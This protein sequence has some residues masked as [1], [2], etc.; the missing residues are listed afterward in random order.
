MSASPE[1]LSSAVLKTKVGLLTNLAPRSS[2]TNEA[3]YADLTAAAQA[4]LRQGDVQLVVDLGAVQVI[5]SA[6]LLTLADIQD[7]AVRL[8]GWL[9]LAHANAIV[10]D[11][12]RLTGFN[13]YVTLMD[14]PA[15]SRHPPGTSP[16]LGD[17][18]VSRG[19]VSEA[20]VEEAIAL[21]KTTSMRMGQIIIDKGW[22]SE[23]DVLSALGEQLDV[24]VV[25]LRAG[26]YDI[27]VVNLLDRNNVYDWSIEE[28]P[29]GGEARVERTLPG[30]HPVF[31]LRFDY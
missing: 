9:K 5:N 4:S 17:I 22:A 29:T 28:P 23:M 15:D 8:G 2:L 14:A 19:V 11:I 31:S 30:L 20:Q 27:D 24:P 10:T 25:R 16:R 6:A 18:L 12:L 1:A 13:R 7:Q 26:I 21:Q 3:L